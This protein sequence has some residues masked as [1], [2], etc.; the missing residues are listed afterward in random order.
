MLAGLAPPEAKNRLASPRL[1]PP[2][3]ARIFQW[4]PSPNF[5]TPRGRLEV[6]LSPPLSLLS[7]G[8]EREGDGEEEAEEG[9]GLNFETEKVG[10]RS[11]AAGPASGSTLAGGRQGRG[12]H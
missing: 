11:L 10:S 1:R 5:E 2:P 7:R 6:S 3:H 8:E 9:G 12:A 4:I